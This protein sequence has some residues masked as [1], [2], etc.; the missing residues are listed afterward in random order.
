MF[1]TYTSTGDGVYTYV[2]KDGVSHNLPHEQLYTYFDSTEGTYDP[3]VTNRTPLSSTAVTSLTRLAA[4][5]DHVLYQLLQRNHAAYAQLEINLVNGATDNVLTVFADLSADDTTTVERGLSKLYKLAVGLY[6][7]HGG[8]ARD[9]ASLQLSQLATFL[10]G[11]AW[12]PGPWPTSVLQQPCITYQ[13]DGRPLQQDLTWAVLLRGAEAGQ[14]S[15]GQALN[16]AHTAYYYLAAQYKA[17]PVDGAAFIRDQA[18]Q[19][20][21]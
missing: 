14:L 9:R 13:S 3:T 15:Q 19:S 5:H 10:L 6:H 18:G 12:A 4:A 11:S 17:A 21:Q 2:D 16:L 1:T 8:L 7:S 20:I